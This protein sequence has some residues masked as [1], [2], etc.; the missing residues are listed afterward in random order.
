MNADNKG[1]AAYLFEHS[2]KGDSRAADGFVAGFSNANVG[3][4]TPNT[5]GAYCDDGTGAACDFESS[6]CANGKVQACHGRGPLFQKLDKGVSSC[7]EIGR[8]QYAGAKNVWVSGLLR[9]REE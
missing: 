7:Y 2:V 1:V 5:L 6:T 9:W 4:T 8:K 3:D